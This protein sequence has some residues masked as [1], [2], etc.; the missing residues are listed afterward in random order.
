[1]LASLVVILISG[2]AA[3][4]AA[5]AREE[6]RIVRDRAECPGVIESS[7]WVFSC[8][9]RPRDPGVDSEDDTLEAE[10]EAL[11]AM[12]D[13]M[14]GEPPLPKGLSPAVR[15]ELEPSFGTW[16]RT[17]ICARGMQ[18]LRVEKISPGE[19][20][21]VLAIPRSA[22]KDHRPTLAGFRPTTRNMMR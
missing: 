6:W 17:E 21:V 4:P 15:A 18:T 8:Q 1:M 19:V 14:L 2:S 16:T 5:D 22:F 12:L 10:S 11:Q 20:G 7:E 3:F 9:R 13:R